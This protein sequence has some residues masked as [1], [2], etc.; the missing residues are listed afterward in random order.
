MKQKD[1]HPFIPQIVLKDCT[2]TS[3]S[4]KM[5]CKAD[6][7]ALL[8]LFHPSICVSTHFINSY[9]PSIKDI[10]VGSNQSSRAAR[11]HKSRI[12]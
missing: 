9:V 6:S 11:K 10:M 1:V 4:G 2:M 5:E 7:K 3:T 12:T 8:S